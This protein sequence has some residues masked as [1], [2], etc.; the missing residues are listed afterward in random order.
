MYSVVWGYFKHIASKLLIRR[1]MLPLKNNT[2]E[3]L[4]QSLFLPCQTF[5]RVSLRWVRV[6]AAAAS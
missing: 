3:V 1:Q 2:H 5:M 6:V 4:V